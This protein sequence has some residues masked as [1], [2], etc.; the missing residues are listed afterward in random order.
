M[1]T[2]K[3]LNQQIQQLTIHQHPKLSQTK[4]KN[5]Q[6]KNTAI[7]QHYIQSQKQTIKTTINDI[8]IQFLTR[9]Q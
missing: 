2:I 5:K 3:T 8:P 4:T 9:K 7:N 1:K 6:L